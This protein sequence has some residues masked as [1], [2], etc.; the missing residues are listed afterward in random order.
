M[1]KMMYHAAA[2]IEQI[3][4]D[5]EKKPAWKSVSVFRSFLFISINW[6]E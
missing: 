2:R 3:F 6:S 5:I 1:M 4:I